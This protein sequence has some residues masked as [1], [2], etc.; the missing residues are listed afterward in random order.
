[1]TEEILFR[2]G[3]ASSLTRAEAPAV[4]QSV[5]VC[6]MRRVGVT[7]G[8]MRIRWESD[9]EGQ[10]RLGGAEMRWPAYQRTLEAQAWVL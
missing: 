3:A 10:K 7:W 5:P 9:R 1:M 2:E 4:T 8:Q 6:L